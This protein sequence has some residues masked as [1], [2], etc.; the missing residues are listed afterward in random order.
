MQAIMTMQSDLRT[1]AEAMQST[2]KLK[3]KLVCNKFVADTLKSLVWTFSRIPKVLANMRTWIFRITL[4]IFFLG[5]S[6]FLA[7]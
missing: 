7:T 3:F 4:P 1:T 5:T 2:A 6:G